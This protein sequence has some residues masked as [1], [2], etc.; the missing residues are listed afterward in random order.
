MNDTSE[1]R[2]KLQKAKSELKNQTIKK[3]GFNKFNNYHYYELD[4]ILPPVIDILLKYDLSSY[5]YPKNNRMY[6]E[7]QDHESK[8]I[9]SWDT[10]LK[11]FESAQNKKSDYGLYM[12]Q[13][14]GL[15]TYARRALLLMAMDIV[16]PND[17]EADTDTEKPQQKPV[18]QKPVQQKPK[19]QQKKTQRKTPPNRQKIKPITTEDI[20]TVLDNAYETLTNNGVEFNIVNAKRTIQKLTLGNQPLYIACMEALENKGADQ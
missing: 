14:Q 11:E 13:N 12:K 9:L 5:F 1:V 17:I 20:K 4:D 15:Q 19:P 3:S 6:L 7:I 10:E 16:E 8:Q 2:F 18:Q